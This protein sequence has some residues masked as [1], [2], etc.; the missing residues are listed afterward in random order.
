MVEYP[1]GNQ[2]KMSITKHLPLQRNA[3][4]SGKQVSM[5]PTHMF[6]LNQPQC[7]SGYDDICV[8]VLATN[9][10]NIAGWQAVIFVGVVQNKDWEFRQ[11]T[12]ISELAK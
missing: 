9:H 12:N 4:I 7:I 6:Q 8:I 1:A 2:L 5:L 10:K 3:L 11:S